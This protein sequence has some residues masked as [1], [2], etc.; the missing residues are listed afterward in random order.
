MQQFILIL[1]RIADTK[2]GLSFAM[3][4]GL[5]AWTVCTIRDAILTCARK[6]NLQHGTR[7]KLKV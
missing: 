6:L 3:F 1:G 5:S 2:C 7:K 4:R